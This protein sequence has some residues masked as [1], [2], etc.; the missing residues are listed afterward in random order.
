ME[1]NNRVT[2][3]QIKGMVCASCV[4]RVEK[5]I[6]KV[7]GVDE[8]SVNFATHTATVRH[9]PTVSETQIADSIVR[10]G[11]EVHK[12]E[13]ENGHAG[14]GGHDHALDDDD[15]ASLAKIRREL[16]AAA[17][18]TIPIVAISMI[19]HMRPVWLNWVLFAAT[20]VVI[21][22]L[23]RQFF[24]NAWAALRHF[25]S[26]M[27]TLIAMG[28]GA[29][30]AYSTYALIAWPT[31]AH[32]QSEHV[33]FEVGAAIV[34]LVLFGRYLEAGARG[35]MSGAIRKLMGL[36]PKY[37]L[38]IRP[39]GQEESVSIEEV[40]KG[41]LLRL[42]PGEK[43]AV[44][45][46]VVEGSSIV[47]E[48]MLTGEPI[49]VEKT[50]G[51]SLSAGTVNETGSLVYRAERVGTETVLSQIVEAVK[52]AQ[53]SKAPMQR[54]V[55]KVSSV[56]VPAVIVFA[57]GTA[58][59]SL[60]LG[61]GAE[62]ALLR[63][64]AVLVIACPCALGL[65]TP[66]AIMVGTGRGAELGVLVKD[67]A[68]LERAGATS[69]ILLDKTGTVTEGRPVLTDILPL[70]EQTDSEV[71]S[72]AASLESGS[73]HPVARAVVQA[74]K[75]SDLSVHEVE[76]FEALRGKGVSGRI[77]GLEYYLVSPKAAAEIITGNKQ[78][79]EYVGRLESEAKTT[80]LLHD[81]K[82][83]LAVLA[84]SDTVSEHSVEAIS[85]LK[86]LGLKT[87]MVTGDNRAT[88]KAIADEVGIEEIEAE[89]LPTEKAGIV[90]KY[91]ARGKVAM[92][93]DGINDAPALAQ[94]D[95]GIA[96]G[97]GTDIAM[98]TAGVTI[99]RSDLRAVGTAIRLSRSTTSTIRWNL[100]WAFIYNSSMIPLAAIGL[101][102][103]ML[104]AGAMALSSVS[105]VLNSLRLRGFA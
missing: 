28:V 97:S 89:L 18:L 36:A 91:Q 83:P 7:E 45:G 25:S 38:R 73:E 32:H 57:I 5:A 93:G 47:D 105:V 74:A 19:W 101:L 16:V 88:A 100:F 99:L 21:F 76:G 26:T 22:Y 71:L 34:T 79:Q 33:Y 58:V 66:T 8:V 65:A 80:F 24:V 1:S 46:V 70:G 92:V 6:S 50:S 60:L 81:G 3:V 10:T 77:A 67:G 102:S 52:R 29:A 27:D 59:V 82:V 90:A 20:S 40:R 63:A 11:F 9:G 75:E 23:G 62:V 86:K 54:V 31:N 87:V 64:V 78:A 42:K 37:A 51:D 2:D 4:A 13:S 96:M 95:V 61:L 15:S 49:P 56:F 104:A 98:E 94:A 39:D 44:D 48:S 12:T 55:D 17:A 68:V 85:I 72:L 14:S 35:R 103:P 53:G 41:D 84:V 69:T 43:V 30:W